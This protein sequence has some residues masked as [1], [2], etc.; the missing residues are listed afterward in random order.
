MRVL[1]IETSGSV[2]SVCL[3]HDGRTVAER[4]FTAARQ[5]GRQL[6]P[7]IDAVFSDAGWSVRTDLDLI[8]MGAGPGSYTGLRVGAAC[9]KMLAHATECPLVGVSSLL[10]AAQNGLPTAHEVDAKHIA[11]VEDAKRGRVY[12]AGYAVEGDRAKPVGDARLVAPDEFVQTL[13]RPCVFIGTGLRHYPD[14]FAGEGLRATTPELWTG[15]ADAVAELGSE[16]F[17]EEGGVD[18]LEFAPT[19]MR[20]PEA[21][22]KR[23]EAMKRP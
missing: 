17:R 23:L 9:A 2:G 16:L 1:A 13:D 5:H 12:A 3:W 20:R 19:Y 4:R 6:V 22:E 7:C 15:R 18:P 11:V 14:A 21:E 8:A 10:A